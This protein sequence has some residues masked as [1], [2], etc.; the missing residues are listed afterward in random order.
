MIFKKIK[1]KKGTAVYEKNYELA[2]STTF[3]VPVLDTYSVEYS[4]HEF[5]IVAFFNV[6]ESIVAL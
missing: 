2:V 5:R 3:A 6:L 4:Q 1:K